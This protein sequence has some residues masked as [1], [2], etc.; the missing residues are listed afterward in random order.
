M[1]R[2]DNSQREFLKPFADFFHAMHAWAVKASDAELRAARKACEAC[3]E[4]NS[5]WAAYRAARALLPIVK[6]EE[7]G[8]AR[9]R[10]A[11]GGG[12]G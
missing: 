3:T 4:T 11:A 7:E 6:S 9:K 2:P 1:G 12:N 5:D 10:A 8:R